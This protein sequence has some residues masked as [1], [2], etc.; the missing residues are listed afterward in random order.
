MSLLLRIAVYIPVLFL[1]A[2]VVTG[3]HHTTA[4]DTA[5]AAAVRTVRWLI[6]SVVLVVSM[7]VLELLFIGW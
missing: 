2:V 6:W 7:F 5:R 4:R 3:Q 1:I